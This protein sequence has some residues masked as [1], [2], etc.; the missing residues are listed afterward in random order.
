MKHLLIRFGSFESGALLIDAFANGAAL[1][2]TPTIQFVILYTVFVSALFSVFFIHD[3]INSFK[4]IAIHILL[5]L[6][7]ECQNVYLIQAVKY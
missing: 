6:S 3:I 5:S 4:Q 2:S 1:L 7:A